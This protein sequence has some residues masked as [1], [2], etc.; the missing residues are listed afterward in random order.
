M[1]VKTVT[2]NHS[3]KEKS[4]KKEKKLTEESESIFKKTGKFSIKLEEKEIKY[5]QP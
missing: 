1:R 5:C 2:L 3:G 4:L